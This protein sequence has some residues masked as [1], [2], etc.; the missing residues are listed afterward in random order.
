MTFRNHQG[1]HEIN[2]YKQTFFLGDTSFVCTTNEELLLSQIHKNT[3][4]TELTTYIHSN[5]ISFVLSTRKVTFDPQRL[6]K[7]WLS[8]NIVQLWAFLQDKIDGSINYVAFLYRGTWLNKPWGNQSSVIEQKSWCDADW[9]NKNTQI[10]NRDSTV[11]DSEA[12]SKNIDIFV[13]ASMSSNAMKAKTMSG[14]LFSS[15]STIVSKKFVLH[16]KTAV[17]L[18]WTAEVKDQCQHGG[19]SMFY[20]LGILRTKPYCCG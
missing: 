13:W 15:V 11:H 8:G 14:Q 10:F 17:V 1:W 20:T 18:P 9:W 5:L 2:A 12:Q 4:G 19:C 7:N 6:L 3:A 16:G